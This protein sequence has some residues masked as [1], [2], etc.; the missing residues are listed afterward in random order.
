LSF[1]VVR[2]LVTYVKYTLINEWDTRWN[3]INEGVHSLGWAG[4]E[5]E[6]WCKIGIVVG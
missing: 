4:R 3:D 5:K 2:F 6:S 1:T